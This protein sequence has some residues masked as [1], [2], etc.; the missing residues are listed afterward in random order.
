M[1]GRLLSLP[2]IRYALLLLLAIIAAFRIATRMEVHATLVAISALSLSRV[3]IGPKNF[4]KIALSA[5]GL[6]LPLIPWIGANFML[7]T[8]LSFFALSSSVRG[9]KKMCARSPRFLL[10]LSPL[11]AYT[12]GSLIAELLSLSLGRGAGDVGAL[13]GVPIDGWARAIDI[14][15]AVCAVH[16]P[17]IYIITRLTLLALVVDLFTVYDDSHSDAIESRAL[18]LKSLK[19]G[20]LISIGYLFAQFSWRQLAQYGFIDLPSFSLPNQTALWD[21]LGRLSGLFSDP[22]A[23][24]IAL[25]LTLWVYFLAN[26]SGSTRS[27]R[28]SFWLPILSVVAGLVSGSRSFI[29]ACLPLFMLLACRRW[30]ARVVLFYLIVII[31]SAIVGS[32]TL[33][34]FSGVVDRLVAIDGVPTGIKRL[35]TALSL[36]RIGDTLMSRGVFL[37]FAREISDGFVLFGVGADHFIDYVPLVGAKL[38][39]ANGW[40]DNSNNF[41]VGIVCE[42]GLVGLIAFLVSISG[43]RIAG[44]VNRSHA[45]VALLVLLLLGCTGPHT[46]FIEVLILVGFIVGVTTEPR[47]L[48]KL[49]AKAAIA[50]YFTA[51]FS[52]AC[53]GLVAASFREQGVYPWGL[54]G[55]LHGGL[56]SREVGSPEVSRWLAHRSVI[57]LRCADGETVKRVKIRARYIPQREPLRV[58]FGVLGG[59]DKGSTGEVLLTGPDPVEIQVRCTLEEGVNSLISR[60]FIWLRVSPAWSPYRAWPGRSGDRRIL[61]VEQVE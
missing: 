22:N 46:D 20:I 39:L 19:F 9:A 59:G 5:L 13:L 57:A 29:L 41:F 43:R 10:W 38:N 3:T 23:L 49:R 24:G 58:R 16:L 34:N 36:S 25:G 18:F 56:Q 53:L 2:I 32:S 35:V 8:W 37:E 28:S 60:D 12:A 40:R 27:P 51:V 42:L 21:S 17:S 11:L 54:N 1:P 15:R 48:C 47:D 33:D 4:H 55:R 50:I 7:V 26:G 6:L 30:R 44:G 61:G 45:V 14:I 52:L 31:S